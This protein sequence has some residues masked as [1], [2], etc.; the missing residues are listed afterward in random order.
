ML[1][2][3]ALCWVSNLGLQRVRAAGLLAFHA[4]IPPLHPAAPVPSLGH[5][6]L[7]RAGTKQGTTG[8]WM[9]L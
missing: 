4:D 8:T 1:P 6:P 5:H 7:L 9:V 3:H 2:L